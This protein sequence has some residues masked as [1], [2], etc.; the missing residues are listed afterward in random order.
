MMRFP[1]PR[2]TVLRLMIMVAVIT[3]A[4]E[5]WIEVPRL[6]R[7]SEQYTL[8]SQVYA[9]RERRNLHEAKFGVN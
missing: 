4:L 3:V 7:L 8:R 6:R 2:F 1:R 9:E 5:V